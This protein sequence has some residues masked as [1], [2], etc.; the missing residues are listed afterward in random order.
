[1][2]S[3]VYIELYGN[4][5]EMRMCIEIVYPSVHAIGRKRDNNHLINE[6]FRS[7]LERVGLIRLDVF[8][9]ECQMRWL[10]TVV[11]THRYLFILGQIHKCSISVDE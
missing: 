5:W 4:T 10:V 3:I 7:L 9:W 8:Y 11:F 2:V 1:M 6:I